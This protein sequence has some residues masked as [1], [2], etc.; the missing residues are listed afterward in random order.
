MREGLHT[1]SCK[2]CTFKDCLSKGSCKFMIFDSYGDGMF[3]D[4]GYAISINDEIIKEGGGDSGFQSSEEHSFMVTS[5]SNAPSISSVTPSS[6]PPTKLASTYPT[7]VPSA[8]A[9]DKPSAH[10]SSVP[11]VNVSNSPSFHP[12]TTSPSIKLSV[13]PTANPSAVS[14]SEASQCAEETYRSKQCG[15]KG[16]KSVCC[17]GLVCHEYQTWRCAKGNYFI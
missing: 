9:T 4:A 12:F 16:G 15:D 7:A 1:N 8:I 10:A 3:D 13:T 5:P 6:S 17:L 2:T 11:T 14:T